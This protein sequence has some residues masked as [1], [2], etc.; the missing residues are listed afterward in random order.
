[1]TSV[2]IAVDAIH[3]LRFTLQDGSTLFA[4]A[5]AMD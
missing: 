3:E 5:G 4:R 2:E 1:V